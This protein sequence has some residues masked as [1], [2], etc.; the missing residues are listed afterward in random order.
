M[1]AMRRLCC[2][3]KNFALD[4]SQDRVLRGSNGW[5]GITVADAA[6][7]EGTLP[8][9]MQCAACGWLL[10]WQPP[11][12]HQAWLP[13]RGASCSLGQH[14]ACC[15]HGRK[16]RVH[17]AARRGRHLRQ[18]VHGGAAGQA[19]R[20]ALAPWVPLLLLVPLPEVICCC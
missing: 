4:G 7:E 8:A 16:R 17:E 10:A 14:R 5:S 6:A 20:L 12:S 19:H 13:R 2:Q 1:R 11:A 18:H 9:G 15:R 3:R